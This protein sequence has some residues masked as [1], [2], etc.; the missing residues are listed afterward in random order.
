MTVMGS[1][2]E[3]QRLLRSKEETIRRLE[4][5]LTV[6]D[7]LIEEMKSQLD[8]YQSIIPKSFT[9][10]LLN[11]YAPRKQRAQGISAAPQGTVDINLQ[12]FKKYSK[13]HRYAFAYTV[14]TISF[15]GVHCTVF[16]MIGFKLKPLYTNVRFPVKPGL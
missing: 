9:N 3:L 13:P 2:Q 10:S 11:G 1:L 16:F 5:E 12:Q 4:H 14:H 6:R 8:K 7:Q 15:Y